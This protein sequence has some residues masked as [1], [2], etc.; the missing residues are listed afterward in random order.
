MGESDGVG[1]LVGVQM[2]KQTS[3][4]LKVGRDEGRKVS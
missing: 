4:F 3:A 2:N 1:K